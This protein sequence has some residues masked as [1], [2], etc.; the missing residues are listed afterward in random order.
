MGIFKIQ[1]NKNLTKHI[2]NDIVV[3]VLHIIAIDKAVKA[4]GFVYK[5][6]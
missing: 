2:R 1:L 3:L 6:S 5:D 4:Q